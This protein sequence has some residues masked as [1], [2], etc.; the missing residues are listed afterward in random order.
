MHGLCDPHHDPGGG[1]RHRRR[2]RPGSRRG[3]GLRCPPRP[4]REVVRRGA[5][6]TPQE[7]Q[8]RAARQRVD[9]GR[10]GQPARERLAV[11]VV[12][13][14]PGN[15][16]IHAVGALAIRRGSVAT[17]QP[18]S[19]GSQRVRAR[20]ATHAWGCA[21]Q[22]IRTWCRTT[23][24]AGVVSVRP[25]VGVTWERGDQWEWGWARMGTGMGVDM[26]RTSHR[27]RLVMWG[28]RR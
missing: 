25:A 5:A 3:R 21:A 26:G 1:G 24:D 6:L 20:S 13:W 11:R 7:R 15:T 17:R 4:A 9:D 2:R 18:K 27:R 10:R 12:R 14:H 16:C 23:T 22:C 28:C 19:R 8:A